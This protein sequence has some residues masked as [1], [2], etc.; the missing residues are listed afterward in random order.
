[1]MDLMT[2]DNFDLIHDF[3]PDLIPNPSPEGEGDSFVK[4]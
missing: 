2:G 3:I 1:M 4:I